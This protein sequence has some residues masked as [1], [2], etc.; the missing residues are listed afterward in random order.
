MITINLGKSGI[1][2]TGQTMITIRQATNDNLGPIVKVVRERVEPIWLAEGL[3]VWC[4]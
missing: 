4:E 3:V 2:E 1:K